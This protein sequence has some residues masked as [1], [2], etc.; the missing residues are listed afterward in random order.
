MV[1]LARSI[2]LLLRPTHIAGRGPVRTVRQFHRSNLALGCVAYTAT[3]PG[4]DGSVM[5]ID[6]Y[7]KVGISHWFNRLSVRKPGH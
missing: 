7:K 5:F 2:Y 1:A 3:N 6:V 4:A